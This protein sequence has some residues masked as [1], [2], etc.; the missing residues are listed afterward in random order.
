MSINIIVLLFLL[1]LIF[2]LTNKQ[3][4]ILEEFSLKKD[5]PNI[6]IQKGKFIYLYNSKLAKIPGINPITFNNLEDYVEFTKWQRS[7]NIDCPILFLQ[8]SYDAQGNI[9][10]KNRPSPVDLQGGLSPI[11]ISNESKESK[12]Y[13]AGRN[14][15][16]YN[17]NTYPA[18]DPLDQYV[19]INTPLDKIKNYTSNGLSSSPMDPNWGGREYTVSQIKKGEFK[20]D[21]VFIRPAK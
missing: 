7:Q 14:N 21:E 5:C 9:V 4:N 3:K 1:G 18:F 16:P 2:I 17:E 20:G 8:H 19:G 6:L 13:D 10:Y 12:L 15:P 11:L